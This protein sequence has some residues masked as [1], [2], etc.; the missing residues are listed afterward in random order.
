M[1]AAQSSIST[2]LLTE[3]SPTASPP[4]SAPQLTVKLRKAKARL[5][6][7]VSWTEDTVD[8]EGMG[9]KKSKCCCVYQKPKGEFDETSESEDSDNEC[10]HCS[11]HVEQGAKNRQ[12]SSDHGTGSPAAS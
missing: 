5:E 7:K 6:K 2:V 3:T 10:E 12:E 11:G 9:K 4:P 1:A 8:N